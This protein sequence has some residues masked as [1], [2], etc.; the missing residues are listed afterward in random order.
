[1]EKNKIVEVLSYIIKMLVEKKYDEV[2]KNDLKKKMRPEEMVDVIYEYGGALTMPEENH[3][4]NFY[5]Y[6]INTNTSNIE[7]DLWIDDKPSD[8]TIDF[9]IYKINNYYKYSI[10]GIHVL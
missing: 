3:F 9:N 8:L 6:E 1:M 4:L 7:F 2:Y 10:E 5:I